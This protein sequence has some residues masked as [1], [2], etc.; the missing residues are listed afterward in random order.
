MK[1]IVRDEGVAGSNPATPTN[2]PPHRNRAVPFFWGAQ[3]SLPTIVCGARC[4]ACS[5]VTLSVAI[6]GGASTLTPMRR[7]HAWSHAANRLNVWGEA[8]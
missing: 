4:S 6:D 7:L 8:G 1:R 2:F 5:T 3:C